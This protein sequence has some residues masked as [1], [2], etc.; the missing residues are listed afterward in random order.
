MRAFGKSGAVVVG[1]LLCVPGVGGIAEAK[2]SK[3]P[4]LKAFSSCSGLVRY[5]QQHA[6]RLRS[7]T[8][9]LLPNAAPPTQNDQGSNEKQSAGGGVGGQD[10]SETNVQEAGI[11]EPDIVKT[12]GSR[13]YAIAGD[14]LHA[15]DVTG[16]QPRRVDSLKLTGSDHQ[17]FIRGERALVISAASS[18]L[19]GPPRAATSDVVGSVPNGTEL[20]EVDLGNA[21][22]LSVVSTLKVEA[23]FVDARLIGNTARL[24]LTS[25]P[26]ALEGSAKPSRG[27]SW[28]PRSVHENRRTKKRV[29]R[30]AVPCSHVRHPRTFAGLDMITVLTI[31]LSKGVSPVDSDAVMS[32]GDTVYSSAKGLYVATERW[33]DPD[34]SP[35]KAAA[36]ATTAIHKFDV[37]DPG[38][39]SYRGSGEV[40][41]FLL[42]QF[43]MSEDEDVL[44][45]ASTD[46]P[47]WLELDN[48][49]E[50]ENFVTTLT[51]RGGRLEQVGRV[52]GLG[53]GEEIFAVRFIGKVGYVVT[54]RQTDP[55][56]TLDLTD[57]AHP[58]VLGELKIQGY[59]AYLHP[60]GD[61]LLLGV[62]Q[63]ADKDGATRG[64]QL[65]R[66]R[67][68]EPAQADAPAPV[69]PVAD[70]VL[71][72][73]VRPPRVPLL[74]AALVGAATGRGR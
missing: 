15:I 71:G 34:L 6:P 49:E 8:P 56:Y 69:P 47:E 21:A 33:N 5:A 58:R 52:G 1:V 54:F 31:D 63:D 39:T 48:D 59:S 62:G 68:V 50:S 30:S 55:L 10:F 41:G 37:S 32:D 23:D 64:T 53:R 35:E 20:T 14:R 65:S 18:G 12:D 36:G 28:L 40:R 61:G 24:V 17:L 7:E 27:A 2:S 66:V 73:R 29:T 43:A 38:S 45:V 4:R 60:I 19:S 22:K 11:D 72:G 3:N 9:T 46:T 51:E 70:L 25:Y 16:D 42:N 44:R 26:D 13:I 67:R 74:G 57:V